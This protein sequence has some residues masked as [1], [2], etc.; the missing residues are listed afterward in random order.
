LS[1]PPD[2]AAPAAGAGIALDALLDD[3][4]AATVASRLGSAA[5]VP[6]RVSEPMLALVCA[7]L[8]R[9]RP[10]RERPGLSVLVSDDDEARELAEAIRPYL[11]GIPVA[12]L[13]HRGVAWGSPLPPAPHLVGERARALDVLARGGVVA[14]S[15]E[16]LVERI[17]PRARR[18]AA[19]TITPGDVLDRDDL[20][21]ALAQ[22]GYDRV[23]GTVEQRGEMSARGDVVDIFPTTGSEPIRVELFGDEIERV[24]AFSALTQRSLRDLG[25]VTIYPSAEAVDLDPAS[26]FGEEDSAVPRDLVPVVPELLAAGPVI[27]WEPRRVREACR[28]RLSEVATGDRRAGYL[29]EEEAEEAVDGAHPFDQLPQ[30]QPFA[31]EGQ[32]PALAARGIAEVENELRSMVRQGLRVVLAFPHSG[33][34]ARTAAQLKR[35][36]TAIA[37]PGSRLPDE[38]GVVLVVSRLRRG[39][40]S[41]ALRLAVLPAAQVLRR[42]GT[43]TGRLG[44]AISSFTDLRPGDYVVHEDHGIGRFAGFDTKTVAGVT[45]DYLA[46]DFRG[47]DK[48]FV[49]HEQIAKVSRYVGADAHPPA[50]SKLGGRA[51]HTLKARARHAVHELAGELLALYAARQAAT[52][53]PVAADGELL[54]RL[55]AAFPYAETDDQARAIDAVKGDLESPHPMDRLIC[56]DVGFGKTEVA[57]RAAM[58]MVE[59]GRQVMLLC[60]TTILA[61]QHLATFRER[62]RDLPV[63][64]EGA[65]R[66]RAAA[67]LRE[68][69]GRFREGRVDVLIGTHRIL[70][71]D[72]VPADLGLV[73][74][75]E[76]QRFGVAQKEILRQLRTEVDVLALSA[77]PI[78]R[79]LHMSLSGIRDIS[80]IATPPRGRRPI[81]THVGEW[82]PDLVAHAIRR[83]LGRDGQTFYLHNRVETIEEAAE[84][85]RG[86]VPEARIAVAHGQM[87]ERQ[88]ERTMEQFL[89]GD[90]DVLCATTIIESGL[91]IPAAGTLVI[92]RADLLGLSQ[93]YQI[94]GR[95]G[96][97][98]LQSYAYLF[99][100]DAAELTPEAGARLAA[101]ADYTELGSGFRV[102]MRDLELR[103]A[104]NLL[105]DEQ[106]GHVAAVG[107]E[108]YLEMLAEAVAELQGAAAPAPAA[109]VRVDAAIDAYVPAAYVGLEAAKID[110]HRRIALATSE[111]DLRELEAELADRFGPVPEPVAN[112]IGIQA[113]RLALAPF[114]P[115]SIAVR[116]DRITVAGVALGIDEARALREA[117]EGSSYSLQRQELQARIPEGRAPMGVAR[118][119][120]ASM[121]EI[122]GGAL[123][124]PS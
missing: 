115:A 107:F 118:N 14:V 18:A 105:G 89:R 113:A 80:V 31:F 116:R 13:P 73:V 76:E 64:I 82:D 121:L 43:D 17:P 24:S 99:Y 61:Q 108:L 119:L 53:E 100:P 95:V 56:G 86:L 78:P 19:V 58:K 85:L 34:A 41:P 27:G 66:F 55:E 37:A 112:L 5:T 77:T 123:A 90:H 67:D 62:F 110:V 20:L 35:V 69:I 46:L 124:A 114:A 47:E 29:R 106:S 103:G 30:G 40:V 44:R 97:S 28:E 9:L 16:A 22:I 65:S 48:L 94:R 15:A 75:D 111:D 26:G 101:L 6:V 84:R 59:S 25:T 36:E 120:L 79:T 98:E 87:S 42:R 54:E 51:W 96:R 57:V 102:A 32:R 1:S 50:L 91:D 45:R 12:Y 72:V 117:V 92:E 93:L 74:V 10:G 23:G 70:S 2:V 109:G 3:P 21:A 104:G 8:H 33:D 39:L 71:R 49:P 88:L 81:R 11:D 122:R 38:A 68:A 60:P 4:A 7:A 52:K 63:V 83:E